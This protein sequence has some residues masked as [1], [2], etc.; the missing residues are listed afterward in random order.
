MTKLA[1][2]RAAEIQLNLFLPSPTR[3]TWKN[4]PPETRDNATELL[5]QL[6]AEFIR[7]KEAS[8]DRKELIDE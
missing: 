6:M 3:P 8:K 2:R 1:K 7:V 4:L 5:G